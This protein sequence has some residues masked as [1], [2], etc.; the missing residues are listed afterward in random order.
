MKE[1]ERRFNIYKLTQTDIKIAETKELKVTKVMSD[2]TVKHYKVTLR[3]F[4]LTEAKAK[5]YLKVNTFNKENHGL[6]GVRKA[7][8]TS[9]GL[10]CI[11]QYNGDGIKDNPER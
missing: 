3:A 6:E 4:N 9:K 8:H 11:E 10:T 1:L 5:M 2:N 7:I